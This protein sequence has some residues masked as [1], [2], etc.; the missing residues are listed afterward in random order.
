MARRL[1]IVLA[2]VV[3]LMVAAV[4]AGAAY[5]AL[6][7]PLSTRPSTTLAPEN[8]APGPCADVQGYTLWLSNIRV[9]NDIVRMTIKFKNSSSATHAAP[10]DLILIDSERRQGTINDDATGC[11][12]FQRTDFDK[13]KTFGPIDV[14]FRVTNSTPPF[15]LHW[16]PDLGAFCCQKDI[17]VWPS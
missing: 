5:T 11:K 10:D 4:I 13:G 9:D 3:V 15:T 17:I 12:T 16:S 8:C 6:K 1:F 7:A 14:C 2:V